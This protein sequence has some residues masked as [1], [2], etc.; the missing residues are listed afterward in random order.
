M[1]ALPLTLFELQRHVRRVLALNFDEP[2]W[3]TAEVSQ[4]SGSGGHSYLTLVQK[5]SE[6]DRLLAQC[7]AVLWRQARAELQSTL[8]QP[9]DDL[10]ST[11]T[12]VSLLVDVT[13]HELYGYKLSVVDI[14]E[15]YTLGKVEMQRMQTI[16]RLKEENLI[17]LNKQLVLPVVAQRVAIISSQNAAGFRDFIE[18][19]SAN[20]YGYNYQYTL[21]QNSMQ[22]NDVTRQL[23]ENL[24][25]IGEQSHAFDVIVILRGGGSKLDL[26]AFDDYQLC[27]SIAQAPLPIITA[28]GHDIDQSVADLVAAI[29]LKTPTAAADFL[30]ERILH[31]ESQLSQT[32]QRIQTAI[33]TTLQAQKSNVLMMEQ[34]LSHAIRT[35]IMHENTALTLGL[36]R[37]RTELRHTTQ[38]EFHRIVSLAEKLKILDPQHT[39]ARGFAMIAAADGTWIRSVEQVAQ[40]EVVENRLADG[41]LLAEISQK[42]SY[43]V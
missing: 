5:N 17:L 23:T 24:K 32:F 25:R 9:I 8:S 12:E 20:S 27:K 40:G 11:G 43:H 7:N 21:F 3:V 38:K 14:D 26:R 29:S 36:Q 39:M 4:V 41:V 34:R 37:V 35:K 31:F 30:I 42:K 2:V 13:F 28:I 6:S 33:T 22:G 15:S 18:H 19:L 16:S 1:A 10:L